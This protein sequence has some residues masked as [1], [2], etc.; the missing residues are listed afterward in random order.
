[1]TTGGE[2]QADIGHDAQQV[3]NEASDAHKESRMN[4]DG[5]E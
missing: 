4:E 5:D 2:N 1:M 3:N